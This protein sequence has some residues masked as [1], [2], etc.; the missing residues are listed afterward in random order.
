MAAT[1]RQI[2][3]VQ[4]FLCEGV[5]H[6]C[7]CHNVHRT[8]NVSIFLIQTS[9]QPT[10]SHVSGSSSQNLSTNKKHKQSLCP[11]T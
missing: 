8:N 2:F 1:N 10:P 4:P 5:L 9:P 7:M 11:T 3:G 6:R